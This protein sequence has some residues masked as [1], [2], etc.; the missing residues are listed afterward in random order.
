MNDTKILL[1][2]M[3]AVSLVLLLIFRPTKPKQ[4][5]KLR[6]KETRRPA[7]DATQIDGARWVAAENLQD[8][9][10]IEVF[11]EAQWVNPT[12]QWNGQTLD[13]YAVLGL[14]PGVS[15]EQVRSQAAALIARAASLRE[16]QKIESA[17]SA[18]ETA[19]ID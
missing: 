15:R 5:S 4:P 6:M 12:I 14:L 3:G 17:L 13:A 9:P 11:E 1:Y 19:L 16:K 18:I 10:P 2:M 8:D 7:S